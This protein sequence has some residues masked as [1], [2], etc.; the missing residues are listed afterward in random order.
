MGEVFRGKD[1]TTGEEVAVKVLLD[2]SPSDRAR[3]EREAQALVELRHPGI[4]RYVAHGATRRDEPYLVMEWLS[5]LDLHKRLYGGKLEI[6]DVMKLGMRVASALGAA[7]VRGVVHRDLKPANLFLVNGNV[8]LAKVLDFGVVRLGGAARMT[9]T[10]TMLGTPGYMAPEQV[11]GERNRVDPRADVFAL[12]A[13]LFECLTGRP[14]F[15]GGQ[16]TALLMRILTEEVPSAR[17]L[18]PEIPEGL[19][20]LVARMLSKDPSMRPANGAEVFQ[21]LVALGSGEGDSGSLGD[22]P[23]AEL[24]LMSSSTNPCV[25]RERELK[26]LRLLME[27]SFGED[28]GARAVLLTGPVGIGKSRLAE[29]L[30]DQL[31]EA[32]PDLEVVWGRGA[33]GQMWGLL[34]SA[35]RDFAGLRGGEPVWT[36]HG[37]LRDLVSRYVEPSCQGDVA[38]FLGEVMEMPFP[39]DGNPQLSE[40]R[41]REEMMEEQVG[42]ALV[43]LMAG[44]CSKGPLLLVLED[45]D[46]ADLASVR[47]L[48]GLLRELSNKPLV[49][50]GLGRP[51]VDEVFPRLW[52]KRDLQRLALMGLSKRAGEILVRR[53]VGDSVA[54]EVVD[55]VL[56]ESEGNPQ[57]LEELVRSLSLS[58]SPT[59]GDELGPEPPAW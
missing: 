22:R 42:A 49:V 45:L 25:G 21:A 34:G 6:S 50:L 8:D 53:A 59:E 19:S 48:D 54:G 26:N 13:V 2:A 1:R 20:D 47:V 12:G 23:S 51:E 46:R 30:V 27:A 28:P 44:V 4:V 14:A 3:F 5:G 55:R 29:E 7:H 57:R 39:D 43:E 35:L 18:V 9:T 24:R 58:L 16:V 10:G 37:N 41:E 33:A 52:E 38:I 36:A 17:S 31:R 11:R 15:E 32:R 56:V 40:A